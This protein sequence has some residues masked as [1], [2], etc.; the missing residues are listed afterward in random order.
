MSLEPGSAPDELNDAEF[1]RRGLE[2][3]DGFQLY[4]ASADSLDTREDLVKRLKESPELDV[5]VVRGTSL[6]EKTLAGSIV[7]TFDR[8]S[9]AKGRPVVVV[10][11]IDE[12]VLDDPRILAR[13][14]E[15]RNE[16]I[17]G[18]DGAIV[19]VAG[20]KLVDS[21]RKAAPDTWSVRAADL[22]FNT[23]LATHP[24]AEE[25]SPRL[26]RIRRGSSEERQRLEAALMQEMTAARRGEITNRLAEVT[27]LE[28]ASPR[29][30]ADLFLEAA[31]QLDS[32]W[33]AV[34]AGVN[35]GLAFL[36]AGERG[37]GEGILRRAVEE[38]ADVDPGLRAYAISSLV[39]A[40][41][42]GD[43]ESALA[44][45]SEA[46][47]LALQSEQLDVA[48]DARLARA[49]LLR[50]LGE[51]QR[52]L[53]E[54]AAA[55]D[56]AA[57]A[58]ARRELQESRWL[59]G[60]LAA[61]LGLSQLNRSVWERLLDKDS[62]PQTFGSLCRAVR[63][64]D[65]AGEPRSAELAWKNVLSLADQQGAQRTL[66]LGLLLF[67]EHR[68]L[69]VGK[70]IAV[71]RWLQ[72]LRSFVPGH[73]LPKYQYILALFGIRQALNDGEEQGL[74]EALKLIPET[75]QP[76]ALPM[77][78]GQRLLADQL[79]LHFLVVCG[80]R[81]KAAQWLQDRLADQ[82]FRDQ[83][84][85]QLAHHARGGLSARN[86]PLPERTMVDLGIGILGGA[87]TVRDLLDIFSTGKAGAVLDMPTETEEAALEVPESLTLE[88]LHP[89]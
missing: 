35:A 60:L 57:R 27:E 13:L 82:G 5:G 54:T 7:D 4:I 17:R 38:A 52:A 59:R 53:D 8:R 24:P 30:V 20:S 23:R 69:W 72:R 85:H 42:E 89:E 88:S 46:V 18:A 25:A 50:E 80:K 70:P 55:E 61:E 79:T 83:L 34:L 71:D 58:E 41:R 3:G 49:R 51:R 56:D 16:L 48:V 64:L 63:Q 33:K 75:V 6:Q 68:S 67:L 11:D 2:L 39:S 74:D 40:V 44:L 43:P 9:S 15:Q 47:T 29:A 36:R 86:L 21:M 28:G 10:T 81:Q 73:E 76:A 65:E 62:S 37:R 87:D 26:R 31:E 19:V 32:P 84:L 45:T 78:H 66:A 12:Q 77:T 1:L 14:N 22:D